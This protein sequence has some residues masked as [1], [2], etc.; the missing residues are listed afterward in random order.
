MRLDAE[1]AQAIAEKNKAIADLQSV[2]AKRQERRAYRLL[3]GLV[4]VGL[5]GAIFFTR[6]AIEENKQD[7]KVL[8][9]LI[10]AK[11]AHVDQFF[12]KKDQSKRKK[13]IYFDAL[14]GELAQ[15]EEDSIASFSNVIEENKNAIQKHT[16]DLKELENNKLINF[17]SQ[18]IN[19]TR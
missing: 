13:D 18:F 12:I 15:I 16:K 4:V 9:E 1:N 17:F 8:K 19:N 3:V 14:E 7:R 2:R 10:E 6:D 11:N 5:L